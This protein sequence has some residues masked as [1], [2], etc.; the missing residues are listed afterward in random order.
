MLLLES[1]SPPPPPPPDAGLA[2]VGETI[3]VV[4]R[5]GRFKIVVA[6]GVGVVVLC[7]VSTACGVSIL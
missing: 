4:R 6:P 7:G 3:G 5:S 2:A 1:P